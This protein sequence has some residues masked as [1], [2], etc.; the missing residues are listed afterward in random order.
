MSD[1]AAAIS[2]LNGFLKSVEAR[3]LRRAEFTTGNT[4]DA[5]DILQDAMIQLA[6][7]YSDRDP[8]EWAPLF[9]RILQNRIHDWGRRQKLR[10]ALYWFSSK[11]GNEEVSE[12]LDSAAGR[13]YLEPVAAQQ[14]AGA[15]RQLDAAIR[16]LPQRQQQ[17]FLLRAWEGMDTAATAA[18]MGVSAGSVK[19]HYSRALEK[20]RAELGDYW[21]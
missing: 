21:P 13:Q 12:P 3:A 11:T 10:R 7:K 16:R 9:A 20:L 17:V 4:D 15:M 18:A 6:Q 5:F 19:T 2:D 1:Q 14:T 8:A